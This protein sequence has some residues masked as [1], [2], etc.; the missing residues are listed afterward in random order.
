MD[1]HGG[2]TLVIDQDWFGH[3]AEKRT[4]LYI[5]GCRPSELP[6][7]PLR[8]E[9]PPRVISPSNIRK[10]DEQWRRSRGFPAYRS[11]VTK[12]ERE[13]TPADLAK[14]LVELARKTKLEAA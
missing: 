9:D 14:W 7:Y 10:R 2:W 1:E 5:C 12:A 13:H 11:E 3:R 8:L 4:R 6:P